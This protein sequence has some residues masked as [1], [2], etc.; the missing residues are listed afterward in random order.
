MNEDK[1]AKNLL[2]GRICDN[3]ENNFLYSCQNKTKNNTCP[4]WQKKS[5]LFEE[6]KR[7]FDRRKNL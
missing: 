5:D 6:L 3:C 7:I 2:L 4:K 1:I